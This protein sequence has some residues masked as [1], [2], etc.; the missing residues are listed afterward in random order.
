LF[1]EL[2]NRGY[3]GGYTQ[4]KKVVRLWREEERER[5]LVRFET[6]PASSLGF[7]VVPIAIVP[8]V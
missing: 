4:M 2:R 7:L 1:R 3:G 8:I 6:A 5:A